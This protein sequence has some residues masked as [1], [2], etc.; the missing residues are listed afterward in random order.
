MGVALG[1][2]GGWPRPPQAL[3][4]RPDSLPWWRCAGRI[5]ILEEPQVDNARAQGWSRRLGVTRQVVQYKH[6]LRFGGR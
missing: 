6:A 4:P 2:A 1:E 5:E 3:I